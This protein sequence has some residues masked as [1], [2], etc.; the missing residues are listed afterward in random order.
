MQGGDARGNG[1]RRGGSNAVQSSAQ[2]GG[3]EGFGAGRSE[4]SV[5][6]EERVD[7]GRGSGRKSQLATNGLLVAWA[8]GERLRIPRER[9]LLDRDGETNSL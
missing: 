2:L 9:L 6:I 7:R 3:L 1:R 4:V 8:Q 5:Q